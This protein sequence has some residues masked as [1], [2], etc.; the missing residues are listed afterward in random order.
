MIKEIFNNV[1][2]ENYINAKNIQLEILPLINGLFLEVNPIPVK[3][4]LSYLGYCENQLRLP[5]TK[6]TEK[7]FNILQKE[8]DKLQAKYDCL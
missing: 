2:C 8:I 1:N 7:N 4:A 5:L 6:M 3:A